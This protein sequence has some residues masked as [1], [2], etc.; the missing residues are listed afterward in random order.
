MR[1]LIATSV[2]KRFIFFG[3]PHVIGA[4]R[5]LLLELLTSDTAKFFTEPLDK[6]SVFLEI[7][8]E[9]TFIELIPVPAKFRTECHKPAC[10]CTTGPLPHKPATTGKPMAGFYRIIVN[11]TYGF[12]YCGKNTLRATAI[13]QFILN[14]FPICLLRNRPLSF[15]VHI[16]SRR[17]NL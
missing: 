15:L 7:I 17:I 10:Q 9:T 16:H 1:T 4:A 2:S 3:I 8:D 5:K 14:R 13:I 12:L 11:K 6:L